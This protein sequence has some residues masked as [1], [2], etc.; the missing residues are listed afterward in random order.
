MQALISFAY[1]FMGL[2]RCTKYLILR[3]I[4][5]PTWI[6]NV[7]VGNQL[8]FYPSVYYFA[9]LINRELLIDDKSMIGEFCGRITCS[10]RLTNNSDVSSLYWSTSLFQQYASNYTV[11]EPVESMLIIRYHLNL[12]E[13][14]WWISTE[15][16]EF[17]SKIYSI[18]N[19]SKGD[20]VCTDAF[21]FR[22]LFIGPF[23]QFKFEDNTVLMSS[24]LLKNLLTSPFKSSVRFDIGIHVRNKFKSFEKGSYDAVKYEAQYW[25]ETNEAWAIFDTF[26]DFL[27]SKILPS[28]GEN[29]YRH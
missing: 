25:L 4:K 13:A 21:A 26:I 18:S 12:F 9:H 17:S 24:D 10:I 15:T 6:L 8:F 11:N 27:K 2:V 28:N 5:N 14:P 16:E 22:Q 29:R 3:D 1:F 7:G 19:C 23:R 20:I